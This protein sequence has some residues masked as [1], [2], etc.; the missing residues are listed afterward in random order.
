MHKCSY[1][2]NGTLI[3]LWMVSEWQFSICFLKQGNSKI[4]VLRGLSD[5]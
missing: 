5:P 4:E 2:S 1:L 3:V